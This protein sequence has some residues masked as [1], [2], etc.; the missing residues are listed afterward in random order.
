MEVWGMVE[1]KDNIAKVNEWTAEKVRL[2]A[3]ALERGETVE[4]EEYP[5]TLPKTPMYIRIAAFDYNIH[6]PN[7]VQ[8]FPVPDEIQDLGVDFGIVALR[9]L[10]NWGRDEFTCLY[11]FRVH[12]DELG[13]VPLPYSED[14]LL[15]S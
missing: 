9:I 15:E 4:E 10:N 12:G 13:E 3:E 14:V 8:T 11:R 7:P 2:R 1:G 6:A 5:K